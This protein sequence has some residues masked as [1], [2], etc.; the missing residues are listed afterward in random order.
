MTVAT[1]D[2]RTRAMRTIIQ[3]RPDSPV[4][5]EAKLAIIGTMETGLNFEE[6]C[7]AVRIDSAV[8]HDLRRRDKHFNERVRF[9][10][11]QQLDRLK[12]VRAPS[13]PALGSDVPLP[14]E[15]PDLVSDVIG[16][17]P[18]LN[19]KIPGN[20]KRL[21]LRH[22]ASTL[23][24]VEA[25]DVSMG[26]ATDL[27][28]ALDEN[29]DDYDEDF[30]FEIQEIELRMTLSIEDRQR[31]NAMQNGKD[32]SVKLAMKGLNNGIARKY[33]TQTR[34]VTVQDNRTQVS[35]GVGNVKDVLMSLAKASE[36]PRRLEVGDEEAKS[37]ESIMLDADST[38]VENVG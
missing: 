23:K 20:W 10:S 17:D 21:F 38:P 8:V 37:A 33:E 27:M 26:S 15:S 6:S 28:L 16:R 30:A 32:S 13:T 11:G 24:R 31:A 34:R 22:Y 7:L 1:V 19:L 25:L 2:E 35:V 3:Y 29:C 9:I 14:V 4:L 5:E 12:L 18:D 36:G